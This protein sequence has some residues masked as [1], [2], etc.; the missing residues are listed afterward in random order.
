MA[1]DAGYSPLSLRDQGF[2]GSGY[3]LSIN[4]TQDYETFNN[5]TMKK[6][7]LTVRDALSGGPVD[8]E[9]RELLVMSEKYKKLNQ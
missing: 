3:R 6:S 7:R 9:R 5:Y 2:H 1:E 8:G 4:P